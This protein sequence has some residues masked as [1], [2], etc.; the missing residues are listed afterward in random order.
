VCA[1]AYYINIYL[2]LYIF[3]I[4]KNVCIHAY[5]ENKKELKLK[6]N[7]MSTKMKANA[8]VEKL[9]DMLIQKWLDSGD[10]FGWILEIFFRV[11]FKRYILVG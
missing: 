8:I 9:K 2:S 10:E 11:I 5:E 4:Y 1:Y 6:L 7:W 3:Y